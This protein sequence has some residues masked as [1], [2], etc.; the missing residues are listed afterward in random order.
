TLPP[1]PSMLRFSA[2]TSSPNITGKARVI[3]SLQRL[4]AYRGFPALASCRAISITA[5]F[6]L[7]RIDP[8]WRH[9]CLKRQEHLCKDTP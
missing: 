1:S 5:L 6:G 8:Q 9:I 7:N 4:A 2:N 3:A